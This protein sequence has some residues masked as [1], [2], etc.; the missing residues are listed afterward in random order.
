VRAWMKLPCKHYQ[1]WSGV[2]QLNTH[3]SDAR[4]SP[5]LLGVGAQKNL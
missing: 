1:V 5:W 2:A 3:S 4:E